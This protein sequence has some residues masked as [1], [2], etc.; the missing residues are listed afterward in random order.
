MKEGIEPH[1]HNYWISKTM[2]ISK[3][4]ILKKIK[5]KLLKKKYVVQVPDAK[6]MLVK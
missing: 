2:K 1:N 6:T 3:L 5:L 4:L